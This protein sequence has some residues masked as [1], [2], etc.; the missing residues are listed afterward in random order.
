MPHTPGPWTA[1]KMDAP[2][3]AWDGQWEIN[4]G[5]AGECVAEVVYSADDARLLAAAPDMLELLL[6]YERWE[7]DLILCD[8]AW[9]NSLPTLNQELHDRLIELQLRRNAIVAKATGA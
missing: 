9:R 4:Y 2:G 3:R 5:R 8:A 6:A 7:A 1:K